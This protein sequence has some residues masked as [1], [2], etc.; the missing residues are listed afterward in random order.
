MF[1]KD[2]MSKK[3]VSID[4]DKTVY[5]ACKKYKECKLGSLVVTNSGVIV[6]IITERDIIERVILDNKQPKKTKIQDIMS[7]NIIN[8]AKLQHHI[9]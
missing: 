1:V 9:H 3:V 7:K 6:G 5:D 2:I 8:V 4:Y